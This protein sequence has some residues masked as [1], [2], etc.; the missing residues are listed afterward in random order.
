MSAA[1]ATRE[2]PALNPRFPLLDSLRAIAALCVFGVHLPFAYRL[3][4]DNP[5]KPYLL[6]LNAGVALFFLISGFLLYRPFAQA[7]F[8][9]ERHPGATAFATRRALRIAP[10]TGWR[11]QRS[12]C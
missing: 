12:C 7:R 10:P 11:S 5:F 8:A 9:G 4:A 1:S 2:S 3:P 6:Q